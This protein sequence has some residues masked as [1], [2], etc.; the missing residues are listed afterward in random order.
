MTKKMLALGGKMLIVVACAGMMISTG[1]GA[2]DY[3]LWQK[4]M[5]IT[6]DG[7]QGSETLTN[8]PALVVLTNSTTGVGFDYDDFLAPPYGDLRFAAA[9]GVTPLEFEVD[10][11]DVGGSSYVWVKVPELTSATTI[12]AYWGKSGAVAPASTTNGAVWSSGFQA[13]WHMEDGETASEIAL[14]AT[15]NRYAGN[16]KSDGSP[17]EVGGVVGK[18]Q[19]FATSYI[20]VSSLADVGTSRTVSFWANGSATS[21]DL[22]MLDS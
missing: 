10:T 22:F 20:D 13:V 12:Y 15:A 8:F 19:L 14:D 18:A 9:D 5:A 2:E 4:K 7:Y 11:W 17:S 3:S 1:I 21:R 6:F 16:K